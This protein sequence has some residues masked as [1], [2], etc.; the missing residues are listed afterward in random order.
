MFSLNKNYFKNQNPPKHI[1]P[2]ELIKNKT[3]RK[4][5]SSLLSEIYIDPLFKP[6]NKSLGNNSKIV[7]ELSNIEWLPIRYLMKNPKLFLNKIEAADILQGNLGNCY[8]LSAVAA[9]AEFPNYLE[10]LFSVK[11]YND[12][13]YFEVELFIDGQ[14]QIVIVDSYFPVIKNTKHFYFS[15]PN[16]EELW[17]IIL[18]KA[19]S[20]VNGSYSNTIA[21]W[22]SDS[23]VAL[24]GCIVEKY[25]LR[26]EKEEELWSR[27]VSSDKKNYIMC[28]STGNKPYF[29]DKTKQDIDVSN[30]DR[31]L[32]SNHAYTLIQAIEV[33]DKSNNKDV[34]LVKIRNPWGEKEWNGNWS[35]SSDC[36]NAE[37]KN[38]VNMMSEADGCFFM[39]FSDLL[40]YYEVLHICF[41]NPKAKEVF[42]T[43][44]DNKHCDD[45]NSNEIDY[46]ITPEYFLI[47][48]P[49]ASTLGVSC[50]FPHWRFNRELDRKELSNPTTLLLSKINKEV[51]NNNEEDSIEYSYKFINGEFETNDFFGFVEDVEPGIYIVCVLNINIKNNDINKYQKFKLKLECDNNFLVEYIDFSSNS[52]KTPNSNNNSSISINKSSL[53]EDILLEAICSNKSEQI[54]QQ[55]NNP[56]FTIMENQFLST[57]IGYRIVI[58]NTKDS[59]IV[60]ENDY[61][62]LLNM[63]YLSDISQTNNTNLTYKTKTSI[64]P[65]LRKVFFGM[66][67]F[68]YNKYWFNLKSS[69]QELK[70]S[71]KDIERK[72]KHLN[73]NS[74][75]IDFKSKID[76]VTKES[77]KLKCFDI[78]NNNIEVIQQ[79]SYNPFIYSYSNL[80]EFYDN[81]CFDFIVDLVL[82][83]AHKKNSLKLNNS[84]K[85]SGSKNSISSK[86]KLRISKDDLSFLYD[87]PETHIDNNEKQNKD[88]LENSNFNNTE[89]ELNENKKSSGSL[90]INMY[91]AS[92]NKENIEIYIYNYNN[93][94]LLNLNKPN[95]KIN[96]G[97]FI[98]YKDNEKDE[99]KN[100]GNF[101]NKIEFSNIKKSQI[102]SIFIGNFKDNIP[103]KGM[104]YYSNDSKVLVH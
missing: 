78:K 92:V 65:G 33:F 50:Y 89:L 58:N 90:N 57:G 8:F 73:L 1:T 96:K 7:N 12:F 45:R 87:I 51:K 62:N 28:A 100:K 49:I 40:V 48:I 101:T 21:G 27:L 69:Y 17:L 88:A 42:I 104:I 25:V 15:Q 72:E 46:S 95:N 76:S 54:K 41:F 103:I 94:T 13:G 97:L 37:L 99:N 20:K 80:I 60:W 59:V 74:I 6:N 32:V 67:L 31:G 79:Y 83:L 91:N 22:P 36:W 66:K 85:S 68:Y 93:G 47:T 3:N 24:T 55:E 10:T 71:N 18:E 19:W 75:I 35:D 61:T 82:K 43:M 77:N 56:I 9:L 64:F 4:E 16:G 2:S 86:K 63:K 52:S 26:N 84:I 5:E 11:E 23:F 34:K 14:W 39:E 102:S 53:L 44:N 38:K 81:F 30:E 70:L 98:Q 29:N